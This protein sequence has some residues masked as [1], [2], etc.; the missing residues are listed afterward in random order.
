[1]KRQLA[2]IGLVLAL[3]PSALFAAEPPIPMKI[4]KGAAITVL[5]FEEK[6]KLLVIQIN[7]EPAVGPN[8]TTVKNFWLAVEMQGSPADFKKRR[9]DIVNSEF[10]LKQDLQLVD[11]FAAPKRG[12]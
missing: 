2:L 9:D 7:A 12:K 10:I 3:L 8:Y 1:M 4:K 6:T 5:Q 11:P